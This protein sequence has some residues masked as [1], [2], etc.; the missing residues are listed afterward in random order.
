MQ[1][2]F[3]ADELVA[4]ATGDTVSVLPWLSSFAKNEAIACY[5]ILLL[6]FA[7]AFFAYLTKRKIF[8]KLVRFALCI[9][10]ALMFVELVYFGYN[11]SPDAMGFNEDKAQNAASTSS[12]ESTRSEP[13][14]SNSEPEFSTTQTPLRTL[15]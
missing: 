11:I 15:T 10:L 9:P 12:P 4:H 13:A 8:G 2:M 1:N 6:V 7:V 5:V 3:I 14:V